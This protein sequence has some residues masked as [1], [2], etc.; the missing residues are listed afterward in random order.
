[1]IRRPPRSTLFPYTT[2]FRSLLEPARQLARRGRLARTL[3]S[4][5]EHDRWRL[6]GELYACGVFAKDLDKLVAEDLDDLLSGRE[7]GHDFL[8]DSFG[9]DLIDELLDDLEVDVGLE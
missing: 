9:A 6:R 4:G 5:H 7:G 3:Q 1:M 8:S 2:L